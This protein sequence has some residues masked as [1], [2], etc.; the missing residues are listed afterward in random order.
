MAAGGGA[1]SD[2]DAA[3]FADLATAR[4]WLFVPGDRPER[5][6]KAV[7]D[8][9]KALGLQASVQQVMADA[10]ARLGIP[11][12][13]AAD[14]LGTD[15]TAVAAAR[16]R[17]AE[18]AEVLRDA[19]GTLGTRCRDSDLARVE[20][21]GSTVPDD[22]ADRFRVLDEGVA[23]QTRQLGVHEDRL[24]RDDGERGK[25]GA[26]QAEMDAAAAEAGAESTRDLVAS[27]GRASYV[28]DRARGVVDPGAL[29]IAWLF[30]AAAD[31][32]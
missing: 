29:V 9:A 15:A 6:A 28:G 25:A 21:E 8:A 4:T 20:A 17:V 30:R 16:S 26:M 14:I 3:G 10:C 18:L 24:R 1:I 12:E 13:R 7:A 2:G 32:R 31:H 11:P 23:G 22:A 5:F 27:R 19:E